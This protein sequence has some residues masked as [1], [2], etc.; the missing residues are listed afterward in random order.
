MD[1]EPIV[2]SET[3]VSSGTRTPG[4]ILVAVVALGGAWLAFT[5]DS[6]PSA[7]PSAASTPALLGPTPTVR[8]ETPP[9]FGGHRLGPDD[10]YH[11]VEARRPIAACRRRYC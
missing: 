3:V 10:D 4:A 9:K 11:Q 1:G 6:S 2:V 5:A 7:A 8:W